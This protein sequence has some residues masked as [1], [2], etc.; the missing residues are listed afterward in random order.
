MSYSFDQDKI[1]RTKVIHSR[2]DGQQILV[3]STE[4]ASN[5]PFHKGIISVTGNSISYLSV[6]FQIFFLVY[7]IKKL[8]R[9]S[10][11]R[12]INGYLFSYNTKHFTRVGILILA[13]LL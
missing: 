9:V 12:I 1:K 10:V 2:K 5:S 7:F 11:Y 13:T 3:K 4:L 8:W 6:L